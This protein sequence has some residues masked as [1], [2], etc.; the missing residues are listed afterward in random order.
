MSGLAE[1]DTLYDAVVPRERRSSRAQLIAV[2]NGYLEGISK[3]D[4]SIPKFSYRCD[5]Y[6]AGFRW[7][8]NPANPPSKG[9]GTC[10]TALDGLTGQAVVNVRFPVVDVTHGVA[11]VLFIIPHGERKVQGAT[12]VAEVIKVV[13][14]KI[15]SIE[16]FGGG[17]K[18][19]PSS[20]FP[21]SDD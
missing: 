17:G 16:E 7:T 19:P 2:V 10:A 21:D 20:G 8:N 13:D 9:G 15:R 1:P 11:V 5:R 6:N 3:H 12:N 14:G 18:Y 4:G